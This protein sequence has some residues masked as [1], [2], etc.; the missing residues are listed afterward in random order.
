VALE[1]LVVHAGQILDLTTPISY[2]SALS[3]AFSWAIAI[4]TNALSVL[5]LLKV[6]SIFF[7]M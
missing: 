2:N 1:P 6:V 4:C 7:E 5:M 3:N